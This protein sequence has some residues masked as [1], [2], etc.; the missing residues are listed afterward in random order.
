MA[1]ANAVE[2]RYPFLDI[3]L[4][5]LCTRIPPNLKLNGFTEKYVLKRAARGLVPDEIVRREKFGFHAPGTPNLLSRGVEWVDDLLSYD[6]VRR[7]G[8]FDPDAVERLKRLHGRPGFTLN[9]TFESD[10]LMIVLT[11]NILLDAFGL[12][13]LT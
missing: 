12:P 11:F 6:R 1:L 5:E 8:Y 10:P 4:V 3:R 9:V 7:Q 2:A 13:N